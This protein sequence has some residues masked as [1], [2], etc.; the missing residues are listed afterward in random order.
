MRKGPP[1]DALG[2]RVGI[3]EAAGSAVCL[4]GVTFR[5]AVR[6]LS[7]GNRHQLS[8]AILALKRR[9]DQVAHV[10][11]IALDPGKTVVIDAPVLVAALLDARAFLGQLLLQLVQQ[12]LIGE[13]FARDRGGQPRNEG[14]P[15]A[16][17]GCDAMIAE[18]LQGLFKQGVA[19][20]HPSFAPQKL[21]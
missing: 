10:V 11:D 3:L 9:K 21:V 4:P 8:V 13:G 19:I 12:R 14:E 1:P 20:A 17:R 6:A 18:G 2:G 5:C 7:D 16:D 15:D